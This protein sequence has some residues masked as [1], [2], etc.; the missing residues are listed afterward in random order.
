[1]AVGGEVPVTSP[2]VGVSKG[3]GVSV[4]VGIFGAV[5]VGAGEGAARLISRR[6]PMYVV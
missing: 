4:A 2:N 5:G 6:F 1:M 3:V